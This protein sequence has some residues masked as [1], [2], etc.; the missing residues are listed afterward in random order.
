MDA[1]KLG[2]NIREQRRRHGYTQAQLGNLCGL[3]RQYIGEIE[4]GARIP[5]LPAFVNILRAFNDIPADTLLGDALPAT[6]YLLRELAAKT[7]RL[8]PA[9]TR[10][11]VTVMNTV[12]AQF[13]SL[14]CDEDTAAD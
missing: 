9:Q 12:I 13:D 8:S 3:G 6:P 1:K 2:L 11:L 5:S 4:R 14:N 7:S 10:L